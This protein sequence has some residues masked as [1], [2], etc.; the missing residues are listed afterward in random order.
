VVLFIRTRFPHVQHGCQ[1]RE[2]YNT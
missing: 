1:E 2:K